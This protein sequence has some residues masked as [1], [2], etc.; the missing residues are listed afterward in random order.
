MQPNPIEKRIRELFIHREDTYALQQPKGYLRIEQPLTSEVLKQHLEGKQTVGVYQLDPKTQTAKWICFDVD[1]ERTKD[2]RQTAFQIAKVSVDAF[3]K[4]S[5]LIEASRYPDPSYHVWVFLEPAM[6]AKVAR[7]LGQK[8]LRLLVD[9]STIELFPKQETVDPNGFGNLVKLPLGLHQVNNLWS[10]FIDADTGNH[11]AP[12]ALLDIHG[13]SL[14]D[15]EIERIKEMLDTQQQQVTFQRKDNERAYR[16][17][18]PECIEGL[19]H[20][21]GEGLRN[22]VCLRL[23]SYYVNF[24]KIPPEQTERLLKEWNQ[25]NKPPLEKTEL[26][27]IIES[28]VEGEYIFGCDDEVLSPQCRDKESCLLKKDTFDAAIFEEATALL[29]SP[30]PLEE[31]TKHLDNLIAGETQN[32]K[33]LFVLLLSGKTKDPSL[34]QMILLKGTEGSG[35]STLQK[36]ADLFETKS[37]G[38]FT[39][40]ALDY[41]D[42]EG[43]E[44]L[45]LQ[46]IGSMD[47]EAQGVS[48]IKFLSSDDKGYTVEFVVRDKDTGRFATEQTVIPPITLVSTTTRMVLDPQFMRR[49]WTINPD[50]SPEQ[51]EAVRKWKINHEN[52]KAEVALGLRK[53]TS[54]EHSFKVLKCLVQN[55]KPQKV[56]IPYPEALLGV[57]D[58]ENMRVRGDYDKLINLVKL[59]NFLNG[60]QEKNGYLI[61]TPESAI[62]ILTEAEQPLTSMMSNLEKRGRDLLKELKQHEYVVEMEE[63]HEVQKH[64]PIDKHVRDLIA[65]NLGKS[66]KTIRRYLSEWEAAGYLSSDEKRPKTFNLLY[67]TADLEKKLAGISDKLTNSTILHDNM[68]KEA[69]IWLEKRLDKITPVDSVV[70]ATMEKPMIP[71]PKLEDTTARPILSNANLSPIQTALDERA[72]KEWNSPLIPLFRGDLAATQELE[73][74]FHHC[75]YCQKPIW[76]DDWVTNAFTAWNPAHPSC[77]EAE[78][79]KLKPEVRER[80]ER[81][82]AEQSKRYMKED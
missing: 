72:S 17:K 66:E 76:T 21:V 31:I 39:A 52:E 34:K 71:M 58:K 26:Q 41:T 75:Y 61:A 55:I 33:V 64:R 2:P 45:K 74:F 5:V 56:V 3:N 11:L 1:P 78:W 60:E 42:L 65:R 51:T 82:Q 44:I 69:Q 13:C 18:N 19:L 32:K 10:C 12:E 43:Y 79:M 77:Y 48:T 7:F 59:Y 47:A 29:E 40:H 22:E 23:A 16:G 28:A 63:R 14:P 24:K 27:T 9:G 49:V 38:R 36:I 15:K 80:L 62:E 57:L 68:Q 54:Y 46:E 70:T 37:V 81:E 8:I 53:E 50:E 73:P 67:E 35:K 30:R 25:K 4:N 20:G 6:D